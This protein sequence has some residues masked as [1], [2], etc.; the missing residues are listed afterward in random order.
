VDRVEFDDGMGDEHGHEHDREHDQEPDDD[1]PSAPLLPPDDRLWRHPSEVASVGLPGQPWRAA[2]AERRPRRQWPASFLSG[3]IGALLVIG[4]VTAV[5]GFRTREVRIP[6]IRRVAVG[7]VEA[8][9]PANS[10]LDPSVRLAD[11]VHPSIVQIRAERPD[12]TLNCTGFILTEDGFV[13]T[14]QRA[15]EGARRVRVTLADASVQDA[16]LVG[17]DPDTGV[18]VLKID[19]KGLTA[20]TLGSAVSVRA[21][22]T[23]VAIGSSWVGVSVVSAV[24]RSVQSKDSPLLFDM[25]DLNA[26][27][28]P[29]VSG[30]PVLDGRGAVIGVLD[31]LDGRGYATPIDIAQD[32]ADQLIRVGSVQYGWLGV[33][34]GD[35]DSAMAKRLGIDGG[36]VVTEVDDGSPAYLAGVHPADVIVSIE[37]VKVPTMAALMY[38][39]RSFRP[40]RAVTISLMREGKPL[41][42]NATLTE[43]PTRY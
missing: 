34:G 2:T 43:R 35:A 6:S 11:R 17:T 4:L 41:K 7:S 20:A 40:G 38:S 36:A 10:T 32:V 33:R 5:G 26:T 37:S 18:G 28:D 30:G 9:A 24:G 8:V 29:V 22:Q 1:A 3:S 12:G 39:V 19:G 25:I 16:L 21:G 27:V 23:A 13:I 14:S 31:V 42:L 15:V